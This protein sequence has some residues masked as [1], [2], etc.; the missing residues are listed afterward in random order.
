[1]S[2]IEKLIDRLRTRPK[3]FTWQELQKVLAHF[4]YEEMTGAGSRRKFVHPNGNIISLHEPH[5]SN[6]LKAYAVKE[7]IDHLNLK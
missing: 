5:P 7:V 6:V 4:G 1:L 3:D 2:K